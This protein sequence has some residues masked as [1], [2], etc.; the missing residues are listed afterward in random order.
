[1]VV[2]ITKVLDMNQ[3]CLNCIISDWLVETMSMGNSRIILDINGFYFRFRY[4]EAAMHGAMLLN[5][6]YTYFCNKINA[7]CL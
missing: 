6:M 2:L 4:R 5:Y 3:H 7:L 1:M